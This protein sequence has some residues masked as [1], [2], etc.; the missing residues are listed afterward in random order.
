MVPN[1]TVL[2][3]S[4]LEFTNRGLC[5]L[6]RLFQRLDLILQIAIFQE[7]EVKLGSQSLNFEISLLALADGR[8]CRSRG[9]R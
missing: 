9:G 5:C 7:D 6:K 8:R 2:V 4:L 3:L 1:F